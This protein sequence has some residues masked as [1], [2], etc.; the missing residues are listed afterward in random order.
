VYDSRYSIRKI[1][2]FSC[3][4]LLKDF[5]TNELV[6]D[7]IIRNIGIIGKVSKKISKDT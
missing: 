6:Q 5:K 1:N 3:G 2:E 4:V 7:A